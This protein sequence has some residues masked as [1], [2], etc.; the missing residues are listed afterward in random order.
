LVALV[1]IPIVVCYQIW[2]YHTFRNRLSVPR[3]SAS[4]GPVDPDAT[5]NAAPAGTS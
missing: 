3:V 1:F 4:E 5:G 2:S